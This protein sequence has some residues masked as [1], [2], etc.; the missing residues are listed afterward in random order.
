MKRKILIAI[1]GILILIVVTNLYKNYIP[2]TSI[3]GIYVN[4]NYS[5]RSSIAEI[6]DGPDTLILLRDGH[7][8]SA[9]WGKGTY[10][11]DHSLTGTTISWRYGYEAGRSE[12][13][14]SIKRFNLNCVKIVLSQDRDQ[15]YEK[16]K[17][18]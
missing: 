15:F 12:F 14:T 3:V 9:F 6:P 18:K 16:L 2:T 11:I 5:H 8:E 7:Y 13:E 10:K 1:L 17:E 4:K